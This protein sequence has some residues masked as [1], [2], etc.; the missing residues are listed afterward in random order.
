M[1]LV[2]DPNTSQSLSLGAISG[3]P[4]ATMYF[5]VTMTGTGASATIQV[6]PRGPL[7]K[8]AIGVHDFLVDVSDGT[9]TSTVRLRV[10]VEQA[11]EKSDEGGCS[12]GTNKS[13]WLA[14]AMLLMITLVSFRRITAAGR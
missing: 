10:V 7:A 1:A 5:D 12:T 8:A 14:L 3:S 6:T 2:A 4:G 9:N 11:P 13:A